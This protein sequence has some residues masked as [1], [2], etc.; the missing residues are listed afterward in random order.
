MTYICSVN[1]TNQHLSHIK[2]MINQNEKPLL[3]VTLGEF[4]EAIDHAKEIRDAPAMERDIGRRYVYGVRGLSKLLGCSISTAQRR[5][6]SGILDNCITR[7]GRLIIIDADTALDILKEGD[8]NGNPQER[9]RI[10]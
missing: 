7:S 1:K 2:K 9:K 3:M 6:S 8:N 10:N 4:L 5:V